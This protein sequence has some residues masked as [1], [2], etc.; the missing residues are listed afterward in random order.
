MK[1]GY[2][3]NNKIPKI[4]ALAE[5]SRSYWYDLHM[6]HPIPIGNPPIEQGWL[7]I[8]YEPLPDE[9]FPIMGNQ[10][11]WKTIP[12]HGEWDPFELVKTYKQEIPSDAKVYL[13]IPGTRFDRF[14]TRHGRGGGW[15]DR[16]L[17]A[18]PR[19]WM[20][21]GVFSHGTLSEEALERKD[22][23]EPM[24]CLI[25]VDKKRPET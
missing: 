12:K 14:G 4:I 15:Y 22:W 1:G 10:R 6:R 5:K 2:V 24:D 9:P 16:F 17:S 19:D 11:P 13:L 21:I 23:D 18:V 25:E 20:R 3:L 8:W 7:G